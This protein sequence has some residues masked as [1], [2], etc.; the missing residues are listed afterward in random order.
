MSL[1]LITDY[2]IL[3]EMYLC[4]FFHS[5][6]NIW[7]VKN[8]T[9]KPY[10]QS[11]CFCRSQLHS[12]PVRHTILQTNPSIY[13]RHPL[14]TVAL[15]HFSAHLT[16]FLSRFVIRWNARWKMD[17]HDTRKNSE[18]LTRAPQSPKLKASLWVH[19]SV[20]IL[21]WIYSSSKFVQ[22]STGQHYL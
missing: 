13:Q 19:T 20:W 17:G 21:V 16:W 9:F 10:Q 2:Y 3:T 15:F 4:I 11:L 7:F 14:L 5:S 18:C 12:H 6:W 8:T 22:W 1:L